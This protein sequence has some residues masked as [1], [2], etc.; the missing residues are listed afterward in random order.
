MISNILKS[1]A[2]GDTSMEELI[3][4]IKKLKPMP[5]ADDLNEVLDTE[6]T[7]YELTEQAFALDFTP[8]E[9]GL[10]IQVVRE[11]LNDAD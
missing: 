2:D 7:I 5:K 4:A 9:Y 3:A 8:A 11:A 1:Y 10:L 6:G